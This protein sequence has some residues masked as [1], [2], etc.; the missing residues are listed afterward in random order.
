MKVLVADA[1]LAPHAEILRAGLPDEIELAVHGNM[2]APELAEQLAE[3]DVFVGSRLPAGVAA[4]ARR[5]RL[6]HAA[7][8]GTDGLEVEGRPDVQVLMTGHHEESIAE[9]VV[10]GLITLRRRLLLQDAALRVGRWSSAIYDQAFPQPHTLD[11]CVA[12]FLG[13]GGIG[14][15]TWR[16]LRVFGAAGIAI[17]E[18]T[19]VDPA[20]HRL[21]WAGRGRESLD[22]ALSESTLLIVS[23]P[24]GPGT[25]GMIGGHE[26]EMLGSSGY[27]VNVARGPVVQEE[28]LYLALR[29][30]ALAGAVLD[31]WYRTPTADG[32]GHPGHVPFGALPNTVLSPH[33]SG[34]T[35]ETFRARASEIAANIAAF[36]ASSA[37][38]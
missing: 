21:L 36:A 14:R 31:V 38:G 7:G 2:P 20:E 33:A 29:D 35:F 8:T 25:T 11:G 19:E 23:V 13:F 3:A 24:L 10:A 32:R 37:R 5:L 6:V 1:G 27:V 30:G 28:P 4:S 22:R 16:A 26:L 12:T 9:F 15:A 34:V 17:T 18:G